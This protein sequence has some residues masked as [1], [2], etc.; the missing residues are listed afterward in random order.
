M[1]DAAAAERA[2]RSRERRGMSRRADLMARGE[3]KSA[4]DEER[5]ANGRRAGLIDVRT[6]AWPILK[7][8]SS[9]FASPWNLGYVVGYREGQEG[10]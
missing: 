8:D 1:A 4:I 5:F 3:H 6:G 9:L 2:R 7:L 10:R